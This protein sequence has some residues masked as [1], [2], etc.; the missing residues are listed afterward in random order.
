M[1][2]TTRNRTPVLTDDERARLAARAGAETGGTLTLAISP[3]K[4][5]V[6]VFKAR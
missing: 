1:A 6:I 4:V 2:G 3:E 5:C